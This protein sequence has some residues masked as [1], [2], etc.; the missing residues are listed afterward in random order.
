MIA[1]SKSSGRGGSSPLTRGKLGELVHFLR[2]HRLIPAHAGKTVV[3]PVWTNVST[4][5]PRSRGENAREMTGLTQVQGSSPLTRGKLGEGRGGPGCQRLI[6]A[7]A[8]KTRAWSWCRWS[9]A[10]HP[11]SRGENLGDDD[12]RQGEAGSSPL[13]RGKLQGRTCVRRSVRL[14]PAHAGKTKDVSV[15]APTTRAHPRSRGENLATFALGLG[16]GGSSPLTRGKRHVRPVVGPWGGLIPAH[17][18]KT[19]VGIVEVVGAGAHPRSRGENIDGQRETAE[20]WG[21]SPLTRGK[22]RLHRAAHHYS[23]LIPAHA[24]KTPRASR[25]RLGTRAHPRSRGENCA[26]YAA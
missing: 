17:A 16:V 5:H 12:A 18:G 1:R 4:A 8:G 22:Q 25:Q 2:G 23:G 9:P 11:R 7:H 21:S 10:A 19:G 13:T 6:P 14:I 20:D 26:G 3:E 15:I 24:G